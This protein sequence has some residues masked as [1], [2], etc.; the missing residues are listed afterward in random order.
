VYLFNAQVLVQKLRLRGVKIGTATSVAKQY[1]GEAEIYPNQR[2]FE[3]EIDSGITSELALF[4]C[5]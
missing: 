2:N 1:W 3:L 4:G 5:E